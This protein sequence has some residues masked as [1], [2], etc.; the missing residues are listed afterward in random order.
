MKKLPFSIWVQP[1]SLV[2]FRVSFH[3]L[4]SGDTITVYNVEKT[5]KTIEVETMRYIK[6]RCSGLLLSDNGKFFY[7]ILQKRKILGK[8]KLS[9]RDKAQPLQKCETCHQLDVHRIIKV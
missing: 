4:F 7:S 3:S 6:G 9:G 8:F 2:G 5:A 1:I